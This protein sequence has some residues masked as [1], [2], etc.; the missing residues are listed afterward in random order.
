LHSCK[1]MARGKGGEVELV[2]E[3]GEGGGVELVWEGAG[4]VQLVW[5]GGLAKLSCLG[6]GSFPC[7]PPLP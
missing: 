1:A 2:W 3:G 5:E 4:G 7:A 6:G